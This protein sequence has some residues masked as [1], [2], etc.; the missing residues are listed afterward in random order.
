MRILYFEIFMKRYSLKN[1]TMNESVLQRVYNYP[2]YPRDS[3]IF[4]DEG[5]LNIDDGSQSRTHWTCFYVKDN[6]S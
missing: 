6:K 2:I 1:H 3:N 5:F 4:S